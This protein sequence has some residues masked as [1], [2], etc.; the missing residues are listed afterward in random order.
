MSLMHRNP[1]THSR[2]YMA[3]YTPTGQSL[4]YSSALLLIPAKDAHSWP[5]RPSNSRSFNTTGSGFFRVK[6]TQASG[7]G[8]PGGTVRYNVEKKLTWA[9]KAES[10]QAKIKS[11]LVALVFLGDMFVQEDEV[12]RTVEEVNVGFSRAYKSYDWVW[13]AIR[14]SFFPL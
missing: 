1:A 14:V 2:L 10:S 3:L 5:S 11:N 8:L 6:A 9:F 7:R 13:D 12:R 4:A